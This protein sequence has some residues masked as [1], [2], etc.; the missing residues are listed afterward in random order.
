MNDSYQI[1]KSRKFLVDTISHL[2]HNIKRNATDADIKLVMDCIKKLSINTVKSNSI[3][4]V[5]NIV[6]NTVISEIQLK[7]CSDNS[8]DVHEML[9]KNL[10]KTVVEDYD[11][12]DEEDKKDNVE[13]SVERFFGIKDIATL[14]KK[15]KEPINS[16]NRAY[17]LLD[18]R[19]RMLENDGRE[20]FKWSHINNITTSQGTFNSIGDI[21]DIISIKLMQLRIPSVKSATTPYNRISILI[22]EL[23]SQS[24]ITHEN[25][26]YHFIGMPDEKNKNVDWIEVKLN[27]FAH[28]EYRFNKPI[29]TIETFTISLASPIEPIVFEPDRDIGVAAF[30]PNT[31]ITFQNDVNLKDGDIVYINYTIINK[32]SYKCIQLLNALAG[33]AIITTFNTI[34]I[35]INTTEI[36]PFTLTGLCSIEQNSKLL[37]GINTSFN[38]EVIH[39]DCL[40]IGNTPVIVD[41]VDNTNIT[42]KENFSGDSVTDVHVLKNN[43]IS[44]NMNVYF[45]SRR[46]L[47][48]MEATYLSS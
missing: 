13:I 6:L 15:I 33:I 37:V 24:F 41:I 29:T 46:I 36:I 39:G 18:T 4:E 19:Y 31:T 21:G 8:I 14:V 40:Y 5:M 26:N 9:K 12:S 42:L 32:N 1:I 11:D 43:I 22:H 34:T 47:F 3:K 23:Q 7:Q 45:G 35:P 48:N 20:Y 2:E 10:G 17:F 27:D 30:G 38:S 28:G 25:N 16:V 44:N